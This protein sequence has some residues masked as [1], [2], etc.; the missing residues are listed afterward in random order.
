MHNRYIPV[1]Y[2]WLLLSFYIVSY[3][4]RHLLIGGVGEVGYP[5]QSFPPG[6]GVL[7]R[8]RRAAGG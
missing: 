3:L 1:Y 2:T 6:A 4:T 7:E 5:V 8:T